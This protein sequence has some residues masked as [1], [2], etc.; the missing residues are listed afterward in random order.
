M[1]TKIYTKRGDQG[2]GFLI[3]TKKIW[4]DDLQVEAIGQIDEFNS[5]IGFSLSKI[6]DV[7]I[8]KQ[9]DQVQSDL[10]LI[11]SIIAQN[12]VEVNKLNQSI[13]QL[14]NYID[15]MELKLSELQNFILPGGGEIGSLLHVVRSVCRRTERR[16][17]S[18]NKK[19]KLPEEILIYI[20][21]LS[22][23][24]F[25]LARFVNFQ[26]HKEEIIWKS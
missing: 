9:L 21:R 16:L 2:K 17:V 5:L 23:Y 3:G 6:K 7:K 24:L 26:Q 13:M 12:K 22:D 11:S 8:K 10:M 20:N 18:L 15:Q 25:I 19:E 4:K 14:E 1:K